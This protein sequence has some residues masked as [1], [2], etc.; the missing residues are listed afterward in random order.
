MTGDSEMTLFA[1][2]FGGVGALL[3][4][5]AVFLVFRT[6]RFLEGAVAA[7]GTVVG[8]VASSSS[9]GGYTYQPQVR[10]TAA[11]GRTFDFVDG[12]GSSPPRPPQG[13]VVP[14]R[15]DPQNPGKARIA[16]GFRLW[17]VPILLGGMGL[18]FFIAGV[19]VYFVTK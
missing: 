5:I 10:F 1:A 9:E 12:M 18:I 19:I 8:H 17:F 16:S 7:T 13:A 14:V 6:R 4:V 3:L 15:Y 11:D 2:I